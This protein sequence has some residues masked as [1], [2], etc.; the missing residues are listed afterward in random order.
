MQIRPI[1]QRYKYLGKHPKIRVLIFERLVVEPSFSNGDR[2][3]TVSRKIRA[4]LTRVIRET[5]RLIRQRCTGACFSGNIWEHGTRLPRF[6]YRVNYCFRVQLDSVE[7]FVCSKHRRPWRVGAKDVCDNRVAGA[8][9]KCDE[10]ASSNESPASLGLLAA[11]ASTVHSW[12]IASCDKRLRS[13]SMRLCFERTCYT[14]KGRKV[15]KKKKKEKIVGEGREEGRK[16]R[17]RKCIVRRMQPEWPLEHGRRWSHM[18]P[19]F[20]TCRLF[21]RPLTYTS[22][23]QRAYLKFSKESKI[24]GIEICRRKFWLNKT[25]IAIIGIIV[26]TRQFFRYLPYSNSSSLFSL[27]DS[28]YN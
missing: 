20:Q 22:T 6:I 1:V 9:F 12:N 13:R 4:N 19:S 27:F 28:A 25:R 23:V 24:P 14:W 8:L 5:A 3:I 18:R 16:E 7:K 17:S 15:E 26:E 10:E 11:F 2:S 21:S